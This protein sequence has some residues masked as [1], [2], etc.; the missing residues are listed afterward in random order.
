VTPGDNDKLGVAP[1]FNGN[2]ILLR[3]TKFQQLDALKVRYI[4]TQGPQSP[5]DARLVFE[6]DGC[7]IYE[8]QIKAAPPVDGSTLVAGWRDGKYQPESFRFGAFISLCAI[9]LVATFWTAARQRK[10][11]T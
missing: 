3:Y 6:S 7:S 10:R 8:R 9:A 1:Q 4:V 2:M 5:G 11:A